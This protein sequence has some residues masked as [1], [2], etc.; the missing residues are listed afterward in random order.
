VPILRVKL[1]KFLSWVDIGQYSFQDLDDE[2]SVGYWT[3]W[4]GWSWEGRP[5]NHIKTE[6][7]QTW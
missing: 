1:P 5:S 3:G 6:I 2:R 4:T 7:F